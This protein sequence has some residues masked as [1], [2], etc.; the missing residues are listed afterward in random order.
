MFSD[1]DVDGD[2]DDDIDSDDD[3]DN[4]GNDDGDDGGYDDDDD[5]VLKM[6]WGVSGLSE[7][8]VCVVKTSG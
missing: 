3:G 8:L 2:I 7:C 5:L 1:D 6:G 4:Y